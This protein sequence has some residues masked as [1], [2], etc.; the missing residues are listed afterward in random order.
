MTGEVVEISTETI[1]L[2]KMLLGGA[3]FVALLAFFLNILT[4]DGPAVEPDDE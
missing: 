4:A 3:C 2:V 1:A